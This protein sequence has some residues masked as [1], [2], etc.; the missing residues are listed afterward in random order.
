[1][2]PKSSQAKFII[3]TLHYQN[4]LNDPR[5]QGSCR[6]VKVALQFVLMPSVLDALMKSPTLLALLGLHFFNRTL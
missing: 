5:L 6:S 2:L 1:M 4:M 3:W